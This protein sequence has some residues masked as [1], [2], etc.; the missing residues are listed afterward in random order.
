[1]T[2]FPAV[3]AVDLASFAALHGYVSDLATPVA[4]DLLAALLDVSEAAARVALLLVSVIAVARHVTRFPAVVANLLA[5]LLRLLAVPGDVAASAAVVA[6]VLG[7]LTVPRDVARLSTA[8]AE[9]IFASAS[10]FSTSTSRIRAVLDPVAGATA[11]KTLV[12]AHS[13]RLHPTTGPSGWFPQTLSP[14]HIQSHDDIE[15]IL[16]LRVWLISHISVAIM[17]AS[18]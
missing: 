9:Q 2:R 8:I 17:A 5:L 13:L 1:M 7:A 16:Q 14:T 12:A 3:I 4:L 18:M 10:T 11:T 6:R 15:Y